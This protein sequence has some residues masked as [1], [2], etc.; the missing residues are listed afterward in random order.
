MEAKKKTNKRPLPPA[1][2]Q[3]ETEEAEEEGHEETTPS[4]S[5]RPQGSSPAQDSIRAGLNEMKRRLLELRAANLPRDDG[6][7]QEL[8]AAKAKFLKVTSTES[9]KFM[10]RQLLYESEE[11]H[12]ER[13]TLWFKFIYLYSG[14]ERALR[15][16]VKQKPKESPRD[17]RKR[18]IAEYTEKINK[19]RENNARHNQHQQ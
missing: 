14:S 17:Y 13:V 11:E 19:V 9:L 16:E 8:I 15:W 1:Q 18:Y 4:S 10:P 2:T 6:I 5:L 7:Q 3:K 12:A